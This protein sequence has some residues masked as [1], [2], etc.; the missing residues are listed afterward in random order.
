MNL[1][2]LYLLW[3]AI[4]LIA[5][6]LHH[7]VGAQNLPCATPHE[8]LQTIQERE[9]RILKL[10][11]QLAE[12]FQTANHT[13]QYIPIKAHILRRNDGTGGLTLADLNTALAQ[14]NRYYINVGS[15]L[16]FYFAALLITSITLSYLTM[17][18]QKNRPFVMLMMLIMPLTSIFPIRYNLATWLFLVM[19]TFPVH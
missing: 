8:T 14:I 19:L 11:Q 4:G 6:V 15:G 17:T 13:V 2:G 9:N 5:I 12:I 18:I 16:Q 10:K 7:E 3:L 1:K